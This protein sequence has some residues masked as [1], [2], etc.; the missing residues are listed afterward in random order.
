MYDVVIIGGGPSGLLLASML[1]PSLNVIVLE[2]GVF[3]RTT[4]YWVTTVRRLEKN[5]LGNCILSS[6][7]RVTVGTFLGSKVVGEGDLAVVDDCIFLQTLIDRCSKAEVDLID[8]ARLLSLSWGRDYIEVITTGGEFKGRLVV[9]ATG[10]GSPIARTFRLHKLSG[11]FS[12]YGAH[13]TAID[14]S[15]Q[16]VVLAH[17]HH[18]GHPPPMLEI[19]PTGPTSAFCAIFIASKRSVDPEKLQSSFGI[20]L[21]NN[22]FVSMTG[23]T[24]LEGA[25]MGVIPIGRLKKRKLPGIVAHGEAA[26]V[27]PP[28]LGTA[29]NDVLEYTTLVAEAIIVAM[30]SR[31]RFPAV[32]VRYPTMKVVNDTLQGKLARKVIK[33]D[34]STF[35]RIVGRLTHLSP[36]QAFRL[37]SGE[38]V[39]QDIPSFLP[40]LGLLLSEHV[41]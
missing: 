11:F 17:V 36:S 21:K 41:D 22:P 19:I 10:G 31:K 33:G 35:D 20:H 13:V 2:Q 12:V 30:R 27:Q 15:S 32:K 7:S 23:A 28:L 1:A 25:R 3:G 5:R 38:L 29:F 24:K 6:A 34:V 37:F 8:S 40:L 26:L 16:D 9:D 18:L 14:L 39:A 4:K